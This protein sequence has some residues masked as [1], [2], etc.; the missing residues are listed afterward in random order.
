MTF[1]QVGRPAFPLDQEGSG[2]DRLAAIGQAPKLLLT[3]T[4]LQNSLMELYGLVS[5]IDSHVFGDAASFREQFVHIPDEENRNNSLRERLAPI[6][7]RTLRK[8]VVEYI[9]FTRRIP[10]TQDF[11]PGDEEQRIIDPIL[12]G[13]RAAFPGLSACQPADTLFARQLRGEFDAVI[14]LYHDQGLAPL[15]AVDFDEAVNVTLGLPHVRTS[16]DHGTAFDIAGK[17]R[18]SP[19]S[20]ANAVTVAWRLIAWRAARPGGI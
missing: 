9:P 15:K 19:R 3:A 6:C 20:F 8:Q 11:T 13:L 16:P 1:E 17:G 12:S 18:A 10:I 2:S 7:I 5:V 4:P 14:A